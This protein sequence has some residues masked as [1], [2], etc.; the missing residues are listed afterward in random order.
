MVDI[1]RVYVSGLWLLGCGALFCFEVA[2]L[3]LVISRSMLVRAERQDRDLR[4][5]V[6][7]KRD[8]VDEWRVSRLDR[9]S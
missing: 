6:R 4:R 5:E 9:K 7:Q 2:G 1:M 8:C 3:M